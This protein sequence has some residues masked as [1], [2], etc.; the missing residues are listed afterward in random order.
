MLRYYIT[1]RRL[2]NLETAAADYI[3]LRDKELSARDLFD[4][5]V[6]A[7]A[8][9]PGSKILVND[10]ADVAI[11]A[12]AHGVHLRSNSIAP[13]AWRRVLPKTFLLGVSCH[14]LD[15][16]VRSAG[17]DFVVFGPIFDTPGKGPAI[18][19]EALREAAASTSTPVLALGGVTWENAPACMEAG[20]AGIA[21]IR[22]FQRR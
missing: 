13:S 3:Q 15:D 10:R 17:A 18:G 9:A 6:R 21:G 12:G 7:V 14:T 2:L 1:D 4:L 5:T 16:I 22:L 11:A 19:L 20:A 8:A